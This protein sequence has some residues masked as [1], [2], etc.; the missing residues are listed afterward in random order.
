MYRIKLSYI[1]FLVIPLF[2]V[3]QLGQ[4]SPVSAAENL[5][6]PNLPRPSGDPLGYQLRDDRCEG[7][8]IQEVA[9]TVLITVSL[10]ESFEDYDLNSNEDLIVEWIVPK[11]Q[12][13]HLRAQGLRPRLYYRM[14]TAR[15]PGSKAYR[16]PIDILRALS[17]PRGDIGVVAWA[18]YSMSGVGQDIYL[19]LRIRQKQQAVQS[20]AYRIVLWPGKEL[21]EVFVSLATVKADGSPGNFIKDGEAL[22]YGY[23]PAERGIEFEIPKPEKPGIYYLEIGATLRS[24]GVV[25]IENRFYHAG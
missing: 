18:R 10:T 11:D 8:Y 12:K 24:G 6:D 3:F 15:N 23:Y 20:G 14:D 2:L 13:V 21:A 16:W 19:P 5:C 22:N 17:I 25:T 7:R 4:S 9:S 1:L